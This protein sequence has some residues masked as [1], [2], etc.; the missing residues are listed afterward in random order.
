M[1]GWIE[2]QIV[3]VIPIMDGVLAASA[4]NKESKMEISDTI[5]PD[6]QLFLTPE[7]N[8]IFGYSF[9]VTCSI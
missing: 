5:S 9:L 2:L 7:K 8:R 4:I 6:F 1:S 3:V